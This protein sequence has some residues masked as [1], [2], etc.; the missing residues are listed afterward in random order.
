MVSVQ[1]DVTVEE[2]LMLIRAYAFAEDRPITEV[3]ADV[4]GRALRFD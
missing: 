3:A 1:A 2:A 4:V